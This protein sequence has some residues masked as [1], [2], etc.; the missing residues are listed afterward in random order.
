MLRS[1]TRAPCPVDA[2]RASVRVR[3]ARVR[4]APRRTARVSAMALA[5]GASRVATVTKQAGGGLDV[6][7]TLGI[8]GS[9]SVEWCAQP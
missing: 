9:G 4:A 7:V 1:L 6:Q 3:A 8:D 2:R 5:A